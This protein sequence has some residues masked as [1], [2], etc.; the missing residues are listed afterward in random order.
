MYCMCVL[1]Q[2]GFKIKSTAIGKKGNKK[3]LMG[4]CHNINMCLLHTPCNWF[5]GVYWD[6]M[7]QE[8]GK[9]DRKIKGKCTM[10]EE[11]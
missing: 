6:V 10:N 4:G 1:G 7:K 9:Y 11:D 5:T 3:Q 8:S 2:V